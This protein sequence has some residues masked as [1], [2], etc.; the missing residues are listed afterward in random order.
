MSRKANR[1]IECSIHE[2]VNHCGAE[3]YC[4]LNQVKIGT[5][6]PNPSNCQCIDCQSFELK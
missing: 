1:S 3:E 4:S 2:C 6:E 5:H